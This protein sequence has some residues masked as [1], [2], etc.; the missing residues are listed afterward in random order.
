MRAAE[1]VK[2]KDY[3]SHFRI[4][5]DPDYSFTN[6]YGLRWDAEHET[7]HPSTF[8]INEK[9]KVMYAKVS[10]THGDRAKV[11]DVLRAVRGE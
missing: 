11:E 7:S 4:L 5:L 1:F 3:P 10:T 2:G 8:V 6:A 9:R